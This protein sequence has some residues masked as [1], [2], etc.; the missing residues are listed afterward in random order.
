MDSYSINEI[1]NADSNIDIILTKSIALHLKLLLRDSNVEFS[2]IAFTQLINLIKFQLNDLTRN[3]NRIMLLQR[4]LSVSNDDLNIWLTGYHIHPYD[5]YQNIQ[6][7]NFLK[8]KR[9][10]SN[11]SSIEDFILNLQSTTTAPSSSTQIDRILKDQ[12]LINKHLNLNNLIR[13]DTD[14]SSNNTNKNKNTRLN[15]PIFHCNINLPEFPPDHTYKFTPQFNEFVTDERI[16]KKNLFNESKNGEVTLL[17]YLNS[18]KNY[19]NIIDQPKINKIEGQ[20][21]TEAERAPEEDGEEEEMLA[22]FGPVQQTNKKPYINYDVNSYYNKKSFDIVKYSQNRIN[23]ERKRVENFELNRIMNTKNPI[24]NLIRDLR[25]QNNISS[26]TYNDS[27]T[28]GNDLSWNG[29][30]IK[31]SFNNQKINKIL[32]DDLNK[33]IISKKSLKNKKKIVMEKAIKERDIRINQIREQIAERERKENELKTL[34]L[35]KNQQLANQKVLEKVKSV[36]PSLNI[37]NINLKSSILPTEIV[38]GGSTT[39]G[40]GDEDDDDIGLFG[41]LES[42]DDDDDDESVPNSILTNITSNNTT[43]NATTTTSSTGTTN[44]KVS[45]DITSP[46]EQ[47]NNSLPNPTSNSTTTTTNDDNALNQTN[48]STTSSTNISVE[49]SLTEPT[50][51]IKGISE[52]DSNKQEESK[53]DESTSLT[54]NN[55]SLVK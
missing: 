2:K 12:I 52:T 32:K 22:L 21:E 16:I 31:T 15:N 41:E 47:T 8:D 23:L 49:H 53:I 45:D 25:Q 26:T 30:K 3:L 54:E 6:L 9:F 48:T 38:V 37:P 29:Y 40:N 18:I 13:N 44:E 50:D 46:N 36:T 33:F 7:N 19:E 20:K 17:H 24:F 4:R 14:H 1:P 43:I 35:L 42:S 51:L 10:R 34:A 55:D 5:L 11:A 27:Q 39:N 28:I